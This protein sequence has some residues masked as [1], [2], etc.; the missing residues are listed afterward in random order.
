MNSDVT[1][2]TNVCIG[3]MYVMDGIIAMMVVMNGLGTVVCIYDK[4]FH[5]KTC[6]HK[7]WF[8][9]V[10]WNGMECVHDRL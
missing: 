9:C 7:M 10:E 2:V 1:M 3:I 4:I 6:E 8:V 5:E